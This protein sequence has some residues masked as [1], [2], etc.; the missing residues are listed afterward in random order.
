M[1]REEQSTT[2]R[3]VSGHLHA[4]SQTNAQIVYARLVLV[5]RRLE[6]RARTQ[7]RRGASSDHL[8]RPVFIGAHGVPGRP[9]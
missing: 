6:R 9:R 8:R 7:R 1:S 4:L 3:L 2:T 5:G